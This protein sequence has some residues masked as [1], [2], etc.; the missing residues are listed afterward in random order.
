MGNRKRRSEPA[1]REKEHQ[2]DK[3][4]R[5]NSDVKNI[6]R[7]AKNVGIRRLDNQKMKFVQAQTFKETRLQ[8]PRRQKKY[9]NIKQAKG[10]RATGYLI[11]IYHQQA[12]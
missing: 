8:P 7:K 2:S 12:S 9:Q 5:M 4:R 11:K 6:A 1:V 10:R 3:R